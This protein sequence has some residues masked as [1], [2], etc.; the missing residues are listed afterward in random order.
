MFSKTVKSIGDYDVEV[1]RGEG[2][3]SDDFEKDVEKVKT[4]FSGT[5]VKVEE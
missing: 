5:P 2:G 4:T 3:D 1:V